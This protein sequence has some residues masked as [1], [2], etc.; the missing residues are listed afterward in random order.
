MDT[1]LAYFTTLTECIYTLG[2]L[3]LYE[4]GGVG[5]WKKEVYIAISNIWGRGEFMQECLCH[6]WLHHRFGSTVLL[7]SPSGDLGSDQDITQIL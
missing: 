3:K 2:Q 4:N 6:K 1:L 5:G 7:P